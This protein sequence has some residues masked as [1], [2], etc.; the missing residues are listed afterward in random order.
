VKQLFLLRS[1]KNFYCSSIN[2]MPCVGG[3]RK[4]SSLDRSPVF[5]ALP[6]VRRAVALFVRRSA[7]SNKNQRISFVIGENTPSLRAQR[8]NPGPHDG[9]P[10]DFVTRLWI[11]SS[12]R[13]SQLSL[14]AVV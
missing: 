4:F 3:L 1:R 6:R 11:A 5:A 12:L 2:K 13:S 7:L 8:S 14:G 9:P 10:S